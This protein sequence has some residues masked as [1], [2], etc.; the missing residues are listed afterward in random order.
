MDNRQK[1]KEERAHHQTDFLVGVPNPD[2]R[3]RVDG[4]EVPQRTIG[5][6]GNVNDGV[7]AESTVASMKRWHVLR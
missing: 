2:I 5:L 3:A 7:P 6:N 1:R 4:N